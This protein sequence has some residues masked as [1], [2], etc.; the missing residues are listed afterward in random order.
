MEWS[1]LEGYS[2]PVLQHGPSLSVGVSYGRDK[3][4]TTIIIA[5]CTLYEAIVSR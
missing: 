1:G 2:T 3:L 5:C 4:F